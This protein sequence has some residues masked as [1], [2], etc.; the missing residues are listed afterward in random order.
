M[1]NLQADAPTKLIILLNQQ[2]HDL[3]RKFA[4]QQSNPQRGKQVYLNTLAVYALRGY[5]EQMAIATDWQA[6][7]SW[8]PLPLGFDATAD[9]VLPEL[10]RLDCRLFLPDSSVA[11]AATAP[12]ETDVIGYIAVQ[13]EESL[14]RLH[15]L[16]F[17]YL[18]KAVEDSEQWQDAEIKLSDFQ[19]L[20]NLWDALN[21]LEDLNIILDMDK[22][23]IRRIRTCQGERE[24]SEFIRQLDRS[25]NTTHRREYAVAK[26]LEPRFVRSSELRTASRESTDSTAAESEDIDSLE[27]AEDFIDLFDEFLAEEG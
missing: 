1:T 2:A 20:E 21:R 25:L 22:E 5:L 26:T 3:A 24:R 4:A 12:P 14:D 16:G 11:I 23:V 19:P 27:L 7:D 18:E 17:K 10:G 15:L 6:S 8:Q 9:L 13:F